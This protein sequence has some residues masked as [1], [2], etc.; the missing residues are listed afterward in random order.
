MKKIHFQKDIAA[1]AE[2]VYEMMLGLK[3]KTTYEHWTSAFN[4]TSTYEGSCLR[5]RDGAGQLRISAVKVL[6]DNLMQLQSVELV[7]ANR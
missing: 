7:P 6:K 5:I 2:K 4:P 3:D 1:S